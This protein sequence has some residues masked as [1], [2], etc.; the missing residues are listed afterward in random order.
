MRILHVKQEAIWSKWICKGRDCALQA[1][2][3]F[4]G[5]IFLGL[6]VSFVPAAS[7]QQTAAPTFSLGGGSY[8]SVQTVSISDTSDG[9]TIY[10]TVDGSTPTT[11]SNIYGMPITVSYTETLK[12]MAIATGY[13]QSAVASATYTIS[14]PTPAAVPSFFPPGGTYPGSI[15]V[16]IKDPTPDVVIYYT[17]DGTMP[18][19]SSTQCGNN[20]IV[21][22]SSTA[23]VQ[24]VAT[25]P[26]YAQSPVSS[27]T[28]TLTAPVPTITGVSPASG[29]IGSSVTI[30]GVNFGGSGT[31]TFNGTLGIPTSWGTDTITVP[32]PAGA[33]SGQIVITTNQG[34]SNGY[35]FT[36]GTGIS[37]VD[38][39]AGGVGTSVVINGTGFGATQGSSVVT[40]NGVSATPT[41]WS[42]TNITV[43]VPPGAS[44]GNVAVQ[45]NGV[46]IT[47]PVF[48]LTPSLVGLSPA[49]G[50]IGTIVAISGS[51]FGAVQGS[52]T[53]VFGQTPA[54]P[55]RWSQNRIVVT[56][57][58]GAVS[59]PVVVTVTGEVS[60]S[61]SFSVG[62]AVTG[63][64]NGTV[65]QSDGVTPVAGAIITVFAGN[66]SVAATTTAQ[67]G[68]YSI[69]NLAAATYSIQGSAAG[70][71]S[72]EQSDVIISAGQATVANL[73]LSGQR[74][75]SYTYDKNGR[76]TGIAD[77]ASGYASYTYDAVGN[78]TSIARSGTPQLSILGFSPTSGPVGTTLSIVGTDF[79]TIPADNSVTVG[80]AS[81]SV[82]SGTATQLVVTVPSGATTGP[83]SITNSN[84]SATSTDSFTVTTSGT[85]SGPSISSFTPFIGTAG[86]P[87]TISGTGFNP[88]PTSDSVQFN[89][90]IAVVSS[91]TTTSISAA[92]PAGAVSGPISVETAG[93]TAV[94]SSSFTAIPFGYVSSNVD[95]VGQLTFGG[96]YSGTISNTGDIGLANFTV[97]AGE[98]FNLAGA[99]VTVNQASFSILKPDGSVLAQGYVPNGVMYSGNAPVSG[100]YEVVITQTSNPGNI[101]LVLSTNTAGTIATGIPSNVT[102]NTPGQNAA[103][104][105]TGTQG[106]L[107]TVQLSGGTFNGAT[108]SI[109]T[110]DGGIL[111]SNSFY[112]SNFFGPIALPVTGIYT[113][114]I[115]PEYGSTGS[116]S[117]TLSLFS[118]QTSTISPGAPTGIT[119][120][121]PGQTAQLTFTATE[122]QVVS[123]SLSN[124]TICGSGT[125][126]SL[127]SPDGSTFATNYVGCSSSFLWITPTLP[128]TGAY[129]L[130]IAPQGGA[131]GS[132]TVT[133]TPLNEPPPSTLTAGTSTGVTINTPGQIAQWTF[134]GTQGQ[135]AS[136]LLSNMSFTSA[137]GNSVS[138]LNPDGSTLTSTSFGQGNFFIAPVEL[139]ATGTY[140]LVIMPQN[141]G[142]GSATVL[143][144]LFSEQTGTAISSGTPVGVTIS[145]PG[146]NA[147]LTFTG[148]AGQQA[149]VQLSGANFPD[150]DVISI[151][152]PDGTTLMSGE[153][154]SLGPV[155]LPASGTYTLVVAPQNGDTGS[156]TVSLLLFANLTGTVL[157]SGTSTNV[158]INAAGQNAQLTFSGTQGQWA[159]VQLSNI[160]F[161]NCVTVSILAPDSTMLTSL[162]NCGSSFS[163]PP[164]TLPATGTYTVVITPQNGGTGSATINLLLSTL[165][166]ISPGTPATLT[167]TAAGQST[168]VAFSGLVGQFVSVQSSNGSFN[169]DCSTVAVN[170][171]SPIGSKIA[172]GNA[173]SGT[174]FQNQISLPA[175][176][177]YILQ[178]V[179]PLNGSGNVTLSITLSQEQLGSL[180]SGTPTTVTI[181]TLG[182]NA[183]LSFAGT[184]GQFASVQLSNSSFAGCNQVSVNVLSP[185]G[186]T[187]A[188]GNI[189][190]Q[191][192]LLGPVTLPA[193]GTY[194]L[195]IS[196]EVTGSVTV[197]VS[198]FNTLTG[199]LTAGTP[200]NVQ[201]NVP[202]QTAQLS[203]T[204][205]AGQWASVQLSGA[206]IP[207]SALLSIVNP[208]GTTLTSSSGAFLGPVTLP[209]NGT[210]T[211]VI[212]FQ[213]GVTG[214]VSAGLSLSNNQ[215]GTTISSGTPAGITIGA[216][217]QNTQLTFTGTAG[218]LASVLLQG[219]SFPDGVGISI[220][221]PDGATLASNSEGFFLGP[222]TLPANGTYTLVFTSYYGTGDATVFLWLF[223]NVTGTMVPGTH[224]N[225]NIGIPGQTA[226]LS[227]S[228]TA[229]Q[230]AS[231]QLSSITF[232][233]I[234][235][236]GGGNLAI[237]ILSPDGGT[238]TSNSYSDQPENPAFGLPPVTLP[239]T[240]VYTLVIAP[241]KT[242]DY[243]SIPPTG[244]AIA[245]LALQ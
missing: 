93:G 52:S 60:N 196:P 123:V 46:T 128:G 152:S 15:S 182:Q 119:I 120:N 81:A 193:T 30:S 9:A 29:P 223:N 58:A 21:S 227:F 202:G 66:N 226:N 43:A 224:F 201:I 101:T 190:G 133:V 244:S 131:T 64:I 18:T 24:A 117:V 194:T 205:G 225:V 79:A 74:T 214:I 147:Q 154:N 210:Y 236:Y 115:A 113:L 130:V 166:S 206:N 159:S 49:S 178:V 39:S 28:Y 127:L 155:T 116:V 139:P 61:I 94:S 125:N 32:V 136:L 42:N 112:S 2:C 78:I 50:P 173:C 170:L 97:S 222:V 142:T 174:V 137:Y 111:F 80:G 204:G 209:A 221:G 38:P 230:T 45:I 10:F 162:S 134:T 146:Q 184:Q 59:G 245:T 33:T 129:T 62:S 198:V 109:L 187:L 164:V 175:T 67:N 124:L 118:N 216:L 122:G 179:P 108:V 57:P 12:A 73:T 197:L 153:G 103:L 188:A 22:L 4:L 161:P 241:Q 75:I 36:V 37:S 231:V 211:L 177:L 232:A 23:T 96:S 3:V 14:G 169:V 19:T 234:P 233:V 5:A 168:E 141:G 47:G 41:S 145:T 34:T 56:V 132:A 240:G 203:F 220:L 172:S 167:I 160:T 186:S 71:G 86:T 16:L 237:S 53:V 35:A 70:F 163:V 229:G 181:N 98:Q 212:A 243:G 48:T 238:L 185:D 104:T 31:V 215:A 218:Q 199:S 55:T 87:V 149:S 11:A 85:G 69:G 235:T 26:G 6:L 105:F 148:A 195:V 140:T 40:F 183:Q 176:G 8:S 110:P 91:A 138:I 27:V 95:F 25:A 156:V 144:S 143:L 82:V 157:S 219:T 102:I 171:L 126:L 200:S 151:L 191:S 65:T 20:C 213:N 114:V 1:S 121:T 242:P 51:N 7:A 13:S 92:V 63:A 99:N 88:D 17:I 83:I 208:D 84:G 100:S 106:Q 44:T 192:L 217:E 107:A 158:T 135:L 150:G 76:L 77:S 89:G 165:G 68:T 189:C 180:T 228:G 54:I 72:G 207:G 239:V 90:Q